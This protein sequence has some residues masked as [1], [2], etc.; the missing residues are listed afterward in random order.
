NRLATDFRVQKHLDQFPGGLPESSHT[1][2]PCFVRFSDIR[3]TYGHF[4]KAATIPEK[5]T[6]ILS[7][8]YDETHPRAMRLPAFDLIS[9]FL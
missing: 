8:I 2:H 7:D 4:S 9:V 5:I 1:I 6:I 3:Y